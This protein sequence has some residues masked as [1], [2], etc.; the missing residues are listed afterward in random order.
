MNRGAHLVL[1]Q[2]F[3]GMFKIRVYF[4]LLGALAFSISN[5]YENIIN[6][7]KCIISIPDLTF[8]NQSNPGYSAVAKPFNLRLTPTPALVTIPYNVT[9]SARSGGHSYAAYALSGNIVVDLSEMK[10]VVLNPDNTTVVQTGT[11]LGDLA[12]SIFNQGGRALPHGTCPYIGTGGH[13]L[14]GGFGHFGRVGGLL[15]DTVV[16]ADIVLANGTLVTLTPQHHNNLLTAI[17]GGGPSFGI[18]VSWTYQTLPAP[19]TTVKYLILF[20][21]SPSPNAL[22]AADALNIY[23]LWQSFIQNKPD[24][25]SAIAIFGNASL[26]NVVLAF[27]GTYYGTEEEAVDLLN[28]FINSIPS[29]LRPN[30]SI[31]ALGWI[32]G[33][34]SFANGL[35]N[36]P[37]NTSLAPDSSLITNSPT[38]ESNLKNF[39]NY[40]ATNGSL[41]KA[42]TSWF[43]QADLYGGQ[44]ARLGNGTSFD[45]RSAFLVY[46]FYA[47]SV[48]PP[49]PSDGISFVD[50]IVKTLTTSPAPP[51]YPNYIDPELVPDD[52]WKQAYFPTK[53]TELRNIKD[54]V[55][56]NGVFDFPEGF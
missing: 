9:V 52:L 46:Q 23:S 4:F 34:G 30:I 12:L 35:G 6:A 42:D 45:H 1:H 7:E 39:I 50:G 31:E 20:P 17:R 25:F 51:G 13:T 41:E 8:F 28:P 2:S 10:S 16:S 26:G 54:S 32:E 48:M 36:G 38:P 44:I 53:A 5:T 47:S 21:N 56:P 19:P 11:R 18:V 24:E 33:L 3:M 29:C 22:P 40:M 49:Y 14:Y 55:D 27:A 37:L 15:L 43:V